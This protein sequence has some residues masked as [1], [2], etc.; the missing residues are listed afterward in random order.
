MSRSVRP[1]SRVSLVR[2]GISSLLLLATAALLIASP[3]AAQDLPNPPSDSE[4]AL[5]GQLSVRGTIGVPQ[6]SLRNNVSGPGGGLH[7][8]L[9]SWTG[10]RPLLI[11]VDVGI[12]NYG[13]TTDQVPFSS[14]IG[15]RVPVEVTTSNNVLETHLSLRLQ[16]RDGRLPRTRQSTPR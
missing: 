2:P 15:P 11:G 9:G 6:G 14:T 3:V 12:L 7:L 16:P 10:E 4:P 8:Y 13:H 5:S 1:R